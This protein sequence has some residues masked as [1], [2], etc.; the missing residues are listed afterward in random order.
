MRFVIIIGIGLIF[1]LVP[2]AVSAVVSQGNILPNPGFE[3]PRRTIGGNPSGWNSWDSDYNGIVTSEFRTGLQSVYLACPKDSE[4]GGIFFDYPKVKAGTEYTFSCYVKNSSKDPIK[5]NA[6]GQ[7]SIEWQK[8][9]KDKDRKDRLIEI[10]R[11]WGP[12]FGPEISTMKWAPFNIRATAPDEADH[13]RFV[14][15]FFNKGKGSGKFY[16]DDVCAEESGMPPKTKGLLVNPS[17]EE[18]KKVIGND[19]SNWYS[20]NGAYNG[21]SVEKVRIGKQSVYISSPSQPESH[22]GIF[23]HYDHVRPGKSYKFS[24]YVINSSKDPIKGNAFGQ[25]SIEWQKKAKD[26]DRKD[27][28]IEISRDWGPSFGPELSTSEWTLQSWTAEAPADADGC[29]FVIQ[30]FNKAGKGTFFVD[31]ATADEK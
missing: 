10:S 2:I 8:K 23:Y 6:F 16:V 29:N 9:A 24:C 31:D 4:A 15:Q 1:V 7:I 20:W 25:I 19:P 30:L 22:S 17:F 14:I 26:K 28:L 21:I 13:C 5:G 18:P 11:D 27:R 3:E 12:S